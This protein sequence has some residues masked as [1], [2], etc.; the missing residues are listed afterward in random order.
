MPQWRVATHAE[1]RVATHAERRVVAHATVAHANIEA[2]S[3]RIE[4]PALQGRDDVT[5]RMALY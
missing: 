1:W 3:T 5:V 2:A 4:A